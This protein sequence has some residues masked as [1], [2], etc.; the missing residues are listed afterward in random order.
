MTVLSVWF[1]IA[2]S[3]V[4]PLKNHFLS[5]SYNGSLINYFC[6]SDVKSSFKENS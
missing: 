3:V 4:K 1:A 2:F 5:L 6:K